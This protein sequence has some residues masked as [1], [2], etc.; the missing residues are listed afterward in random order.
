MS[1]I[2]LPVRSIATRR[3]VYGSTHV[4][5]YVESVDAQATPPAE[6][7]TCGIMSAE[8]KYLSYLLNELHAVRTMESTEDEPAATTEAYSASREML[9]HAAITA[10]LEGRAIPKGFVTTDPEGGVRI[11]WFSPNARLHLVIRPTRERGGYIYHRSAAGYGTVSA[12]AYSL[13]K[14]LKII[15]D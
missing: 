2:S 15:S 12:T 6:V 4:A 13:A 14:W 10:G 1:G 7:P 8:I 11:E 5:S 9:I 3:A